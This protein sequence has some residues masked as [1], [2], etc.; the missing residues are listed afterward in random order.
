MTV[1]ADIEAEAAPGATQ[2]TTERERPERTSPLLRSARP[3]RRFTAW[4]GRVKL[5][6][7]L[8]VVLLVAAVAVGFVTFAAMTRRI[9]ALADPRDVLL[10]I[11]LNLALLL[12]FGV[13]IARRVAILWI[14]R[15]RNR[16]GARLHARLVGL[17]ALV[18][19]TPTVIVA[20]F[21]VLLF[22][23]G[24]QGWFSEKVST[25]VGESM[26][27]A[28]SYLDEHA[29]A[30]NADAVSMASEVDRQLAVF[31]ADTQRL[32]QLI[33]RQASLRSLSEAA[34]LTREGQ[35]LARGGVSLALEFD[36]RLPAWAWNAA[37][38]GEALIFRAESDDRVRAVVA[39]DQMQGSYLVV[40][41]VIDP[42]VL[43]HMDQSATAVQLYRQ[44]EGERNRMIIT[45]AVIFLV[46]ALLLLMAAVW[47]G[48]A[49]ADR[50]STPI[51][52]LISAAESVGRGDLSARVDEPDDEQSD[53]VGVLA[54]SFNRMTSQLERQRRELLNANRQLEERRRFIEAVLS[55]VSSGVISLDR[56]GQVVLPNRAAC[57]LLQ[58][59]AEQLRGR[60]LSKLSRDVRELLI[61]ARR[62]PGRV[63]ESEVVLPR[64][65]GTRTLF[66]RVMAER[67]V[68]GIVG[69]V[70]TFDDVSD[71]LS[72]QRKAA[73]A[74]VARRIAH[75]IKNPLTPIQLSAER[76]KRKYLKQIDE[77]A[78]TFGVLS[79]TIVRH[80][81]DI[82]RMVDEFSSFARMPAPQMRES[83]LGR[84]LKEAV[85]LQA[86]G[87]AEIDFALDLPGRPVLRAID[88]AQINR[89]LT[90]ILKNA[91][92]AVEARVAAER[93]AG[94]EAS[95]P[96][97]ISVR[98]GESE[99]GWAITV[100]DN[101]RGLPREN[102]E[103]LTEPYVTTRDKG[104]GLGLAIVK[105]IMEDHGGSLR[106]ADNPEG[107]GAL[108]CLT[109]A[110]GEDTAVSGD[111][112]R[113]GSR[114]AAADSAE[115]DRA[116]S[117]TAHSGKSLDSETTD[118]EPSDSEAA[119][120]R[121]ISN[122]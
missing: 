65:D 48:L 101:G 58:V 64:Q 78:E 13:L 74:D 21:S 45:F 120:P 103:R 107:S 98:L 102:R 11:N 27:V 121:A 10:L 63:H 1:E 16:A 87:H 51:G 33:A 92:E 118:R 94:E 42:R 15:R 41:R 40:G 89:A 117:S 85:V 24:L 69:Y 88:S 72:A 7:R 8:A 114:P 80:V 52:R 106:L 81:G 79:D 36:P 99:D 82:G 35:V 14:A 57:E 23:Y 32:D 17:F 83:D 91:A 5:E 53:E 119:S 97:R 71:L 54:G 28:R 62:R 18:T 31:G 4:A 37:D 70:V 75:E 25:A 86:N 55:G 26:A 66:V 93:E 3:W 73:W 56:E 84:L 110:S 2:G 100:A 38:R 109:F 43:A 96:G 29:R 30:I 50:L 9:D 60:K 6:Q 22:D 44:L 59:D 49:F 47:V 67:D 61:R 34:V 104:T 111:A 122:L 68:E 113:S 46:V 105:K 95:I 115:A 90:N 39:L 116:A 112:A 77:D 76:L 108:V 19:A 12:A 20:V